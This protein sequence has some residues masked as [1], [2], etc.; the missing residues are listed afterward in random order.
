MVKSNFKQLTI[1]EGI[2]IN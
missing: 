2:G 1:A